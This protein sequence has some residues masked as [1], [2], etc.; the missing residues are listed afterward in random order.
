MVARDGRWVISFNGEI[1]NHDELRPHLAGT[2]RGRSDTEVLLETIAQVG[3]ESALV[4]C[5]GMFAVAALDLRERKLWLARDRMGEK[6]LY[7]GTVGDSFRVASELK[8]IVVGA[9]GLRI[10]RDAVAEYVRRS[11][12]PAPKTIWKGISKLRPGH[13][14]E[15][16]IDGWETLPA[17]RAWWRVNDVDQSSA[18][19]LQD[20]EAVETLA[21]LLRESVRGQMISDVPIGVFLSG[22]I[23]SSVVAA[24]MQSLS[25]RPVRTFTIGFDDKQYDESA[26]AAAI[27]RHLGTEHCV[28]RVSMTDALQSVQGLGAVWDEPFA[29]ESQIPT[30]ILAAMARKHVTVC[31]SGDGGDEL[32]AGYTRYERFLTMSKTMGRIPT[33]MRR[34]LGGALGSVP[35]WGWDLIMRPARWA[36]VPGGVSGDRIGKLRE[37]LRLDDPDEIYFHMMSSW[38]D[39]GVVTSGKEGRS[40]ADLTSPR[41]PRDPLSRLQYTDQLSYLPDD[42]LV[43]VDRAAMYSSLET[44]VPLLDHR[45][46]DFSWRLPEHMKRRAGKG[47]WILRKVLERYVPTTI[48]DGPKQGFGIPLAS[49][50]RGPLREWAC[51]LLSEESLARHG[52]FSEAIVQTKLREHLSGLRNWSAQLWCILMFQV[53]YQR[54]SVHAQAREVGQS[55]R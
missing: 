37:L 31:L 10:D 17:S 1:Y 21:G 2:L 47:K 50:L 15:I 27:A 3:F 42:I 36:G 18:A 7:Y 22:G 30:A 49:W 6:P 41:T 5:T 33:P 54:W 13:L 52:M 8:A 19:P 25:P 39:S 26:K 38:K 46:V 4:K 34:A 51:D 48:T 40:L 11:Y 44:R 14:L 53:W 43:K 28:E 32:F 24:T 45:I 12:I 35:V 55:A 20:A 9:A 29:D 23:D 16:P